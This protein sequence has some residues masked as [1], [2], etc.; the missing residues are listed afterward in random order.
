MPLAAIVQARMSSQRLFGKVLKI[1]SGKPLLGYVYEK[2]L[3]CRDLKHIVIS[4]S[5]D[6]SDDPIEAFCRQNKIGFFRGSLHDVAGRFKATIDHY[7]F[8]GF[9]RVNADSPLLDQRLIERGLRLFRTHDADLV[10][11]VFPRTYPPGQS[12]EVIRSEAFQKGYER[13]TTSEDR[14]H[15]TRYFYRHNKDFSIINFTTDRDYG[16]MHFT[17]DTQSDFQHICAIVQSM[18]RAPWEYSLEQLA[19][20]YTSANGH[21]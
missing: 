12:V 18:N 13:I 11:N 17:V 5:T 19:I 21:P 6:P 2:L 3:H 15:V 8:D 10:T 14:E 20:L 1:I 7:G 4:T 16:D 9:V